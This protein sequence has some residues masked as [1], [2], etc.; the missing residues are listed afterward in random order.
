MDN[1]SISLT[2]ET[3]AR[4]MML[5]NDANGNLIER[6]EFSSA[7]ELHEQLNVQSYPPGLYTVTFSNSKGRIAKQFV[8]Q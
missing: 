5:I 7:S 1:A 6:K 4:F 2:A 8:K 3:P